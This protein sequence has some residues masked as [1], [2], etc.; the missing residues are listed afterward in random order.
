MQYSSSTLFRTCDVLIN[1][2]T[3]LK[4][5]QTF[6]LSF[7]IMTLSQSINSSPYLQFSLALFFSFQTNMCFREAYGKSNRMPGC[8]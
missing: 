7:Q 3:Y 1:L 2:H 6:I 8:K 4:F 5:S